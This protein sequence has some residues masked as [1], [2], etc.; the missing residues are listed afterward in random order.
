MRVPDQVRDCCCF[1]Y[2]NIGA[3][4]KLGGTGFFIGEKVVE[5]G[6]EHIRFVY[7]VTA[8]HIIDKIKEASPKPTMGMRLNVVGG[9]A[10]DVDIPIEGWLYHPTDTSVDAAIIPVAHLKGL[11]IVSLPIPE[12]TLTDERIKQYRIGI[13]DEVCITGLFYKHYGSKRNSP[14]LRTGN[15]AMMTGERIKA[16]KFG[17]IDAYLIELRSIG[18]LSGSPVFVHTQQDTKHTLLWMGLIHG[19]WEI[20]E[21]TID[22][23]NDSSKKPDK[24][25]LNVGIGIVVPANKILE[26]TKREEL[27]KAKEAARKEFLDRNPPKK[28]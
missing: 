24:E 1:I 22:V 5:D 4:H 10:V 13:G 23:A 9:D 19:H 18:G 3:K 21:D 6:P 20:E 15:I 27:I 14:I 7:L 2:V 28:P 16:K 8:K 12:M 11:E 25:P 17:D 26:I